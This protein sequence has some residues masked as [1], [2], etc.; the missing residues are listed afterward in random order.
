ML[1]RE[2][3]I[4]LD[5]VIEKYGT[6]DQQNVEVWQQLSNQTGPAENWMDHPTVKNLLEDVER[7]SKQ[8]KSAVKPVEPRKTR[9]RILSVNRK[10][11]STED[12]QTLVELSG[13][14]SPDQIAVIMKRTKPAIYRMQGNLKWGKCSSRLVHQ[15]RVGKDLSTIGN[16]QYKI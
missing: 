6:K 16:S 11:W 2:K 1:N 10:H 14:Y 9:K 12:M 5:L 7:E 13:R 8:N 3:Q 4:M 15:F